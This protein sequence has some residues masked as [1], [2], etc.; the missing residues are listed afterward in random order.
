M[1]KVKIEGISDLRA[2]SS[3]NKLNREKFTKGLKIY[4]FPSP[5]K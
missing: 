2:S 5:K 3:K 4:E 1:K